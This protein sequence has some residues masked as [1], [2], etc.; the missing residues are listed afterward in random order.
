MSGSQ[1][2]EVKARLERDHQ[3]ATH[4]LKQQ[5]QRL[6]TE[7]SSQAASALQSKSA[8]RSC[9][10]DCS[11]L[12][13]TIA[14]FK[15]NEQQW[16]S[17]VAAVQADRDQMG[18][19]HRVWGR[20]LAEL[21]HWRRSGFSGLRRVMQAWAAL[22]SSPHYRLQHDSEMAVADTCHLNWTRGYAEQVEVKDGW[23]HHDRRLLGCCFRGDCPCA[24]KLCVCCVDDPCCSEASQTVACLLCLLS[25]ISSNQR[26]LSAVLPHM[27]LLLWL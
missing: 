1:A 21:L 17:Q 3:A 10:A 6:Q 14:T 7:L 15:S 27:R 26:P 5:L 11:Q 13:E 9:Q 19:Q 4:S 20:R 24:I 8:L 25:A 12:E 16:R 22:V 18:R 2:E 23:R